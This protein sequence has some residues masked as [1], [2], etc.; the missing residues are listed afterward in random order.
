MLPDNI[1]TIVDFTIGDGWIGYRS[2]THKLPYMRIE[3]SHRQMMYAKHK[4]DI[5]RSYD[6]NLSAKL[7]MSTTKKNHGR[8]YYQI[9]TYQHQDFYTAYKWMYNKKRKTIDKALLRH[10]DACSLAYWFMD[11]GTAKLCNYTQNKDKSRKY[12]ENYKI[13]AYKLATLCF[14]YDEN[15]LIADWLRDKFNIE[16]KIERWKQY[17][18]IVIYGIEN[19]NNF[20][21]TIEPYI[22]NEM[23]YKIDKPHTFE[24][25]SWITVSREETERDNPTK[26]VGEATVQ[27]P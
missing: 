9:N 11:D 12:F 16:S 23:R 24:G 3:H 20:R 4:E 7:Y 13:H 25:M 18:M 19:K 1:K 15:L 27:F 22:I 14:S 5:L 26:S 2:S 6:Y 8:Y 10:L 17:C 21:S